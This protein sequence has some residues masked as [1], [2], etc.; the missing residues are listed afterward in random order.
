M[1]LKEIQAAIAELDRQRVKLNKQIAHRQ[2]E[3]DKR[4][5]EVEAFKH[6][7]A[8]VVDRWLNLILEEQKIVRPGSVE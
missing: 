8:D 4:L 2:T 6:E 1:D 3:A 7:L 5:A